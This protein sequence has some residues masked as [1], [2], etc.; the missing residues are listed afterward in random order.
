MAAP[1]QLLLL[2]GVA[3]AAAATA[4]PLPPLLGLGVWP[5]PRAVTPGQPWEAHLA[6]A[7]ARHPGGVDD[8]AAAGSLP[9]P[10]VAPVRRLVVAAAD[11]AA[12]VVT[13]PRLARGLDRYAAILAAA[14]PANAARLAVGE[15][16]DLVVR[17][18]GGGGSSSSS[19][20]D[21]ESLPQ[22]GT[23]YSYTLA[24][25][26]AT[27]TL[28]AATVYGALHGL[29]TAAQLA[30]L[31]GGL[32]P[33]TVADAPQHAWRGLLLDAGRRFL[34]VAL[35]QNVLDAMAAAK[36]SVLHWHLADN[37][38]WAVA[39]AAFPNVTAPLAGD[40][41]GAY[42]AAD[43]AAVVA[44]AGDRGIRVVPEFDGPAHARG[45]LALAGP[46]SGSGGVVFCDPGA[47]NASQLAGDAGNVTLGTLSALHAEAGALFPDDVFHLGADETAAH[48]GACTPAGT[49][50]LEAALV[51]GV[52]ARGKTAAGWEELL[53]V[54]GA[55]SNGTVVFTWRAES[56]AAVVASGR[57]A[58]AAS[59][60]S[61]YLDSPPGGGFPGAWARFW[62]DPA[63]GLP[64]DNPTRAL[65]LGGEAAMWTDAYVPTP[66][67]GAAGGPPPVAAALFPPRAD[68]AFAASLGGMVWPRGFVAAGAFYNYDPA[69]DPTS[70]AF[71]ATIAELAA[72]VAARGGLVC[73]A[74]CVCDQLSAC[75][76]P[77]AP[78]GTGNGAAG[79]GGVSAVAAAAAAVAAVVVG[80]AVGR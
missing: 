80:S 51:A 42:S 12:D 54:S 66:Q 49:A 75:G 20:A 73:P 67:C 62:A 71:T 10:L 56:P 68:A 60:A 13:P 1:R 43:V 7:G 22:H 53:F 2:I 36:L 39:S 29:E 14:A 33:V 32:P 30:R 11:G 65:L 47:A 28:T 34:P 21:A 72:G 61:Y 69:L 55:A 70:P 45:L 16:V 44:Y 23:D 78:S 3:A 79:G 59:A 63:A 8:D 18:T 17:L 24:A 38:R 58:V 15:G 31:H 25:G 46:G 6:V 48:V 52:E 9:V 77:Y 76:R 27:A 5:V 19:D 74:G 40:Y 37:C 64:G 41:A 26:G 4:T 50:V 35:V 57:R